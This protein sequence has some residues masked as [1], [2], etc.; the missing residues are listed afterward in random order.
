MD[1]SHPAARERAASEVDARFT[2][3]GTRTILIRPE[4]PAAIMQAFCGT[5]SVPRAGYFSPARSVTHSD[6]AIASRHGAR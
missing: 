1:P 3:A 5:R 2:R 6:P 4:R